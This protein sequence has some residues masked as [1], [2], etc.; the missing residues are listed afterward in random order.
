MQQR[1]TALPNDVWPKLSPAAAAA[2]TVARNAHAA[3]GSN[4]LLNFVC[5]HLVDEVGLLVFN[6]HGLM[7]KPRSELA[8]LSWIEV[9]NERAGDLAVR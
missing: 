3:L 5:V 4:R 8:R 2:V 1:R 7:P 6:D 9:G